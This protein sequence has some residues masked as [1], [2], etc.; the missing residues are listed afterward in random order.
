LDD[1]AWEAKP[2]GKQEALL[3]ECFAYHEHLEENGHAVGG[4]ALERPRDSTTLRWDQGQVSVTDG[5][6]VETKEHIGGLLILEARDLNH[7]IQLISKHPALKIGPFEIRP[8]D[9]MTEMV[10][11]S[12]KRR[13]GTKGEA[14]P[15]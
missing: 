4:L 14:P 11:E 10:L 12:Q 15:D 9:D 8:V 5:P 2:Q 3:D 1:A 6:F 7:A 13:S